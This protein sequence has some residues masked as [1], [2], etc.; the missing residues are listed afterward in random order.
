[1]PTN[2][3]PLA[4][5]KIKTKFKTNHTARILT[6]EIFL[7]KLSIGQLAQ[8]SL[9][10]SPGL[11]F[12]KD[13][14]LLRLAAS[15]SSVRASEAQFIHLPQTTLFLPTEPCRDW[16]K[17][18][19]LISHINGPSKLLSLGFVVNLLNWDPPFFAPS[20]CDPRVQ[21]I[22]FGGPQGNLFVLLSVCGLN[23]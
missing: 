4:L 22:E 3:H 9:I 19:V 10:I 14:G 12:C 5:L 17:L 21:I 2:S 15:P 23:L 18:V 1:M 13:V 16:S 11:S 20:Y 6:S 8:L 7:N